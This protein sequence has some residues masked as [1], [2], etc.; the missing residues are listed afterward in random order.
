VL[1]YADGGSLASL[2]AER[3]ALTAGEVVSVAAPLAVA[4]AEVHGRGVVHGNITPASV[5][6]DGEGTPLLADLGVAA[7][8]GGGGRAI[9]LAPGFADP[10]V[11][12]GVSVTAADVHGLAAVCHA[13]LS[14]AAPYRDEV[15]VPLR[16]VVSGVPPSLIEAIEAAMN[17]DFR[18][19]PDAAGFARALYAACTPRPVV[20][21]ENTAASVAS[22]PVDVPPAVPKAP[23]RAPSA[24]PTHDGRTHDG[25]TRGGRRRRAGPC[26]VGDLTSR[27]PARRLAMPLL[28]AALL[29]AAVLV[30]VAWAAHDRPAAASAQPS[31]AQPS[32]ALASS[33]QPSTALASSDTAWFRV[34]GAL[35]A[36]RDQAFADGDPDELA[37]VYVAGSAALDADRRTLVAMAAAGWRAR[38]LSLRLV[39]VRVR[40][41][42][43]TSVDLLV[44]DTLPTYEIVGAD[45]ATRREPGRGEREWLVTLRATAVGGPWR[46][47]AIDEG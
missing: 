32:T 36:A 38:D 13:A 43:Q 24:A 22:E 26:R 25:R 3:G 30:G 35:D 33:A 6:F 18:A 46:I 39:S 44:R 41:Q 19:R 34:M 47:A 5:L 27:L 14:G 10:A 1:D 16:S 2:L 15:V 17:P 42:T 20:L 4:L 45:G 29:A 31:T 7:L 21:V 37:G 9:A 28:T 8:I 40:A 11:P 12:D 23:P